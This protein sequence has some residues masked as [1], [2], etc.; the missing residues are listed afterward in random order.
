MRNILK[1]PLVALSLAL[2]AGSAVASDD[3]DRSASPGDAWMTVAQI[4]QKLTTEG[5][6]VRQVKAEGDAY[7]VYAIDKDGK[8]VESHVDPMT[9]DLLNSDSDD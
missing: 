5:Y 6:D 7:E 2:T 8:R 1:L 9:G 4:T 3:D